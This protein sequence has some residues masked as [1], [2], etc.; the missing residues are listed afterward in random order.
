MHYNEQTL[1]QMLYTNWVI[2]RI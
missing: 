1:K 2:Y